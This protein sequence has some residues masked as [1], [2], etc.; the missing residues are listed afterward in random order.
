MD[1]FQARAPTL[2]A[3]NAIPMGMINLLGQTGTC[4]TPTCTSPRL[5]EVSPAFAVTTTIQIRNAS[6]TRRLTSR[7]VS[8][9]RNG[10]LLVSSGVLTCALL[11]SA[12]A[13]PR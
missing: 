12:D 3:S 4:A 9:T 1:C 7:M 11:R 6:T 5:N 10:N 13:R 8:A 2:T